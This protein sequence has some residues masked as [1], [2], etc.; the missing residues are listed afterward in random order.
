MC[1]N[2]LPFETSHTRFQFIFPVLVQPKLQPNSSPLPITHFFFLELMF[3]LYGLTILLPLYSISFSWTPL[4]ML[5]ICQVIK[6]QDR[7]NYLQTVV[8]KNLNFRYVLP[9]PASLFT[10]FPWASY[11][12]SLCMFPQIRKDII[13]TFSDNLIVKILPSS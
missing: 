6:L 10:V 13:P 4:K 1:A 12:I 5:I 3:H 2:D 7:I 9:I 8:F 11:L